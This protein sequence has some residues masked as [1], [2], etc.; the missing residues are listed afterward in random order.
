MPSA[1]QRRAVRTA[2]VALAAAGAVGVLLAV[3]AVPPTDDSYYPKCQSYQ[4]LGLHCPGCGMTRAA[5]ALLTGDPAQ[6]VAFNPLAPV[7]LPLLAVAFG[8][9][10]FHWAWGRPP[11]PRPPA[12]TRPRLSR[13]KRATP[14]A[15]ALGLIL[16]GVLRNVPVAP[17]NLLA[18]HELRRD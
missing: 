17:F 9:S 11:A 8:R 2:L 6:A 13:L 12:G 18:P 1:R 10:L 4:L 14:W 7:A 5:H 15:I 16:F 3:R